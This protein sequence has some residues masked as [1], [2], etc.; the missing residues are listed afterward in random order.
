MSL[1]VKRWGIYTPRTAIGANAWT[2]VMRDSVEDGGV[3]IKEAKLN[4]YLGVVEIPR[5]QAK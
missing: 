3:S 5:L 2:S 4:V 1:S